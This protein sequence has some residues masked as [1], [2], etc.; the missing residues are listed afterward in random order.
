MYILHADPFIYT[1]K[2]LCADGNLIPNNVQ[3]TAASLQQLVIPD[4]PE[5]RL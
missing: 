1:Q 4:K 2:S 5:Q 3:P